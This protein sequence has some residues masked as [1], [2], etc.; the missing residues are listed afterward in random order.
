MPPP[1]HFLKIHLNIIL[2][3]TPGSFNTLTHTYN[4]FAW[5]PSSLTFTKSGTSTQATIYY[6]FKPNHS[7][8]NSFSL[9]LWVCVFGP[10]MDAIMSQIK[11]PTSFVLVHLILSFYL[12][13]LHLND[14]SL[15][16]FSLIFLFLFDESPA[17]HM[18]RPSLPQR[19]NL[20]M[21]NTNFEVFD[22]VIF[23]KLF[24]T[25]LRLFYIYI[26]IY[27]YIST[28]TSETCSS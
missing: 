7:L 23:S 20:L 8:F 17:C 22:R 15:R 27:I 21:N 2:P 11:A 5:I 19:F 6:M 13:L 10:M 1:Y 3:S 12:R 14:L 9:H 26:Y 28:F 24:L 16:N 25:S 4:N 18:P